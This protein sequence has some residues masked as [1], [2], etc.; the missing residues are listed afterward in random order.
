MN[1]EGVPQDYVRAHMWF[2][3]SATQGKQDAVKGRDISRTM[4][5]RRAD[6]GGAAART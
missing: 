6:R 1:G 4:Y 3:L 5:D 2:N